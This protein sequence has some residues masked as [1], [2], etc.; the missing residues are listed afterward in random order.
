MIVKNEINVIRRCLESVRD[1]IDAWAIVDTGSV[2]GTQGTVRQTLA[3]IPGELIEMPWVDFAVCRNAAL[4]LARGKADYALFI[5]ADEIFSP[6]PNFS[7]PYLDK[8]C[9]FASFL[10]ENSSEIQRL[11]LADIRLPWSWKGALHEQLVAEGERS[12]AYLEGA[13]IVVTQEGSRSLDPNK[14]LKDA[15]ML[16]KEKDC[17]RSAFYAALSYDMAREKEKA[18]EAYRRRCKMAGWDEELFYSYY[19]SGCLEEALGELPFKSLCKAFEARPQR[20]EPL[21]LLAKRC[22]EK[23]NPFLAWLLAEFALRLPFPK[24]RTFVEGEV[25]EY[26][27]LIQ[28]ADAATL[29]GRRAEAFRIMGEILTKKGLPPEKR[30]LIE[31]LKTPPL[32]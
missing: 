16:E 4:T 5:D 26:K 6:K 19:R 32:D 21:H 15:A 10:L 3:S 22:N 18:L 25:Y 9:Y 2:D 8:D 23:G 7:W 30:R 11:F 28:K 31:R 29:L 24:D 20:A 27:L 17:P 12:G 13:R 14:Y 1:F